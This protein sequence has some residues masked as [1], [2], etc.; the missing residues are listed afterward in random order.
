MSDSQN[1]EARDAGWIAFDCYGSLIDWQGGMASFLYALALRS[2]DDAPPR[3]DL[4][5]GEWSALRR[6]LMRE[7]FQPYK[8]VLSI[9][10]QAWCRRLGYEWSSG[11]GGAAKTAMR[12]FQ[13]FPEAV[14]VLRRLVLGGQKLALIADVDHDIINHTL[15][16][17]PVDFEEVVVSEDCKS[18]KPSSSNFARALDQIGAR[19]GDLL[20][21]T[22]D[23]Q[24]DI[25]P[26]AEIGMRTA[27][28]NRASEDAPDDIKPDHIW[29]D[30]W[31]LAELVTPDTA[32]EL[33]SNG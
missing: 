10:L 16:Q 30:L 31:E 13:P 29:R 1:L 9:S 15:N 21:V 11:Y 24:A 12:S 22:S 26:A 25:A 33:P 7:S 4:L 19:A 18:Y 27:W 28:L 6:D 2:G 3:A 23:I 14:P 5:L 32:P 8:D 17:L 20:Y